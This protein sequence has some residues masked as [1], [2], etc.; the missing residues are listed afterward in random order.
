MFAIC[1][2]VIL[3]FEVKY[4]HIGT[5][6][7]PGSRSTYHTRRPSQESATQARSGV[8]VPLSR[9][10]DIDGVAHLWEESTV[11]EEYVPGSAHQRAV[12][13]R[14]RQVRHIAAASS[15]T[16]GHRSIAR[17]RSFAR[18]V[19]QSIRPHAV[20]H[21]V[22]AHPRIESR[23]TGSFSRWKCTPC[24]CKKRPNLGGTHA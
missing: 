18:C 16:R 13:I 3:P 8:P 6:S 24:Q 4:T 11:G 14:V 15:T 10:C 1:C 21:A 2:V 7:S 17:H 5:R 20:I 23:S 12:E 22:F 19:T 9:A